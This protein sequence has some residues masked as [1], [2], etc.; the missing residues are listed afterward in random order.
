MRRSLLRRFRRQWVARGHAD[1]GEIGQAKVHD[2]GCFPCRDDRLFAARQIERGELAHLLTGD[3]TLTAQNQIDPVPSH[4]VAGARIELEQAGLA[5]PFGEHA[6]QFF[7]DAGRAF[8]RDPGV[9]RGIHEDR[10]AVARGRIDHRPL[11]HVL[12]D[13]LI[14]IRILLAVEWNAPAVDPVLELA[15]L[16]ELL[17]AGAY[18]GIRQ[19]TAAAGAAELKHR[20]RGNLIRALRLRPVIHA[21]RKVA[22]DSGGH[23]AVAIKVQRALKADADLLKVV[24]VARRIEIALRHTNRKLEIVDGPGLTFQQTARMK[25]STAVLEAALEW[26]FIALHDL[27]VPLLDHPSVARD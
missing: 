19:I 17:H 2:L 21:L 11:V 20:R 22:D 15:V 23:L 9:V 4:G 24:V 6:K 7:P 3:I 12:P 5:A 26:N 8:D 25:H 13:R 27:H 10:L 16:V 14:A 18:F 1:A